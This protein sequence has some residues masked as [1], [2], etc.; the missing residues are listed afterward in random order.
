MKSPELAIL[1]QTLSIGTELVMHAA[2]SPPWVSELDLPAGLQRRGVR[3]WLG[4]LD[5]AGAAAEGLDQLLSADELERA[6]RFVA[7]KSRT[8]FVAS[9][10]MVR[11]ILGELTR[12]DPVKVRFAYT[13]RGKPFLDP[14]LSLD[15]RFNLA[16]SGT[17]ALLAT[18][19]GIDLGVDLEL[20]QDRPDLPAL[21][22]SFLAPEE[23]AALQAIPSPER[24]AM[25]YR[26]W[27][28]KEA[29]LKASG[30]GITSGLRAPDVSA[31][32]PA[33][34]TEARITVSLGGVDWDIHDLS[35]AAGYAGAL[36]LPSKTTWES[37][38]QAMTDGS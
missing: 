7:A 17:L 5:Q 4:H 11:V 22:S 10:T 20:V 25:F 35:P 2:S 13:P 36:A 9:R 34:Q 23:K 21:V 29:V 15:L 12:C 19:L 6:A 1:G 28:R 8:Q 16:H 26:I 30:Q 27:T 24:C 37:T 33:G 38:Q 32:L 3:V 14:A 18:A 31:A